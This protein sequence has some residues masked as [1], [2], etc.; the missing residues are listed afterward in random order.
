MNFIYK[1]W[2]IYNFM[3]MMEM[4]EKV[5]LEQNQNPIFDWLT[6]QKIVKV[7]KMICDWLANREYLSMPKTR[8]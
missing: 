5:K 4:G 3:K 7:Y 1:K 8:E 6:S 2:Y